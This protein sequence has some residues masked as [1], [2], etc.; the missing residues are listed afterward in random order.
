MPV[1]AKVMGKVLIRK[2]ADGVDE[3]LRKEQ[4]GFRRERSTVEQILF[5]GTFWSKPLNG[6]P[7]CTYASSI[8]KKHSKVYTGKP[9][10]R[11]WRVL[12]SHGNL[13]RWLRQCMLETSVQ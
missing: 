11:F 1:V 13:L 5:S 8:M 9:C 4:A 6:M 7:S 3:K 10:G 12:G 2:I